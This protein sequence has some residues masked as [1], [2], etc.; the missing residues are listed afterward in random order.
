MFGNQQDDL[1]M[2]YMIEGEGAEGEK[3]DIKDEN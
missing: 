2:K 1:K 3:N